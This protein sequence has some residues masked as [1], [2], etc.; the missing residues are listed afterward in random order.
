[1]GL[2]S[3]S[4]H[5]CMSVAV[6]SPT[7]YELAYGDPVEIV[8]DVNKKYNWTA[9]ELVP[10]QKVKIYGSKKNALERRML[11]SRWCV[12]LCFGRFTG[13]YLF[14]FS[15]QCFDL[16]GICFRPIKIGMDMHDFCLC[17]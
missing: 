16:E 2:F 17:T 13:H 5:M 8:A 12:F 1:M 4:V 3:A 7:Q 11:F 15:H 6:M 9:S 14:A 10:D